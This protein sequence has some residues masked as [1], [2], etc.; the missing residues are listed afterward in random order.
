[1]RLLGGRLFADG[2]PGSFSGRAS[3]EAA[4]A[5]PL[6]ERWTLFP[7]VSAAW[8]GVESALDVP[9]GTT[10]FQESLLSRVRVKAVLRPEAS[11][12]SWKA[13]TG[14]RG[15]LLKET[16]DESWFHGLFDN[17]TVDVGLE[18]ERT[19][20]GGA[21]AS[22][23][24]AF[25]RTLFP[26]YS[27]LESS[28]PSDP[29]GR[30]LARELA[31]VR[32]LDWDGH[33]F[34][35]GLSVPLPHG[36]DASARGGLQLRD[37]LEQHLVQSDG[38]LGPGTRSDVVG[39]LSAGLGASG[40]VW[41]DARAGGGLDV[42]FEDDVSDQAS[43]DPASGR[44]EPHHYDYTQWSVG[45]RASLSYGDPRAPLR[46]SLAAAASLRRWP[47]RSARDA[48]GLF[49]GAGLTESDWSVSAEGRWPLAPGLSLVGRVE[50]TWA[51]AN[52][53]DEA[54]HRFNYDA[55]SVLAGV[56]LER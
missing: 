28:A 10:L 41:P 46:L 55:T 30:P 20:R 8:S 38:L 33:L 47:H 18:A 14:W 48:S 37:Y 17:H 22:F 53:H 51:R 29:Y 45:P 23:S 26:N 56:A 52:D 4:S 43:F 15:E 9:G 54:L 16:K 34:S 49:T 11:R 5:V 7:T 1:A 25:S 24:Y 21:R 27:S 3:G 50:R 12:W 42:S 39:L 36:L 31:G 44:Y 40:E 13:W 6:G 32:V 19:A 2:R 35:A